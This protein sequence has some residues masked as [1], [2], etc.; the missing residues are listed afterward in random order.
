MNINQF[1]SHY[2]SE[3]LINSKDIFER[4]DKEKRI[5]ELL[6]TTITPGVLLCDLLIG[7]HALDQIKPELRDAF[8]S[9]MGA[10]ADTYKEIREI[11]YDKISIGDSSVQGMINKILGQIGENKFIRESELLGINARLAD[12]GSQEGWDVVREYADGS[13]EYVQVKL[14]SEPYAV[15]EKIKEVNEKLELGSINDGGQVID[16]INFAVPE[17]IYDEVA[18]TVKEMGLN[19]KVYSIS[20]TN[21]DGRDLAELGFGFSAD[22]T[23][24]LAN[25]FTEFLGTSLT[26]SALYALANGFLWY[27]GSKNSEQFFK[28]TIGQ[29]VISTG[30]LAAGY[31]VEAILTELAMLGG[32]P[33]YVLV[34]GT[35]ITTRAILNRIASRENY[36]EWLRI[37]NVKFNKLIE[38]SY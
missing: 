18:N 14:Y 1:F 7:D 9:L 6:N 30:A 3:N 26:A 36:V 10:K 11:L 33:S 35:T 27:K 20:L 4:W 2:N 19:T 28:D 37:Q 23:D 32:V 8:G 12:S 38:E 22:A 31:S 5:D 13:S 17:D 15:I 21:D 16:S 24:G 25:F 29:S 34:L